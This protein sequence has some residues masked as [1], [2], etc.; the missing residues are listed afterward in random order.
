MIPQSEFTIG[1]RP[2]NVILDPKGPINCK[3]ILVERL[4]NISYLY[5]QINGGETIT[6]EQPKLTNIKPKETISFFPDPDYLY[7]FNTNGKR[8]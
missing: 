1:F 8:M 3:V 2:E 6:I 7:L 5:A 4:G